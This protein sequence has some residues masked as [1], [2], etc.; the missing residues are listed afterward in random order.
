MGMKD[1]HKGTEN[2][3]QQDLQS[4]TLIQTCINISHELIWIVNQFEEKPGSTE[5]KFDEIS[6]H[7][8]LSFQILN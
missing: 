5:N 4:K 3:L 2:V 1:L 7:L 8:W 6:N